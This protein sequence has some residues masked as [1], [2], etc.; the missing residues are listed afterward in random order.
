MSD[1][2]K[3]VECP[4]DAWQGLPVLMPAEVKADYL[5]TLV[6]AG[7]KHIDAVSFVSPKAVPQMADS[8]RVLEYLMAP[9]D[10]EIIAIAV[11]AKGAERAIR[12]GVVQTL[13]FPYSI[14]ATFLE[15]NQN[16]RPEE[17]IEALE[18]IGTLAF[19]G[20]LDVVA[21]LSM[22]FGNPYGDAWS[23]DE[24]VDACD[25]LIDSGVQRISL[26]DTVGLATPM[27]I[28]DTVA[29]VLAVHD[30]IEIGVHLHARPEDAAARIRAAYKAGCRRFD[31]AI[32]G[33]GG[34]PF[35]QDALVGNIPTETL[36]DVLGELGAEL[37]ELLPLD[38]LL[39]LNAEIAR[40]YGAARQ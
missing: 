26:A 24:V 34:C 13:G 33:L 39:H 35:A 28:A 8:E 11:N 20:G 9:E 12:T 10:V 6:E 38:G 31:A 15:R 17:A 3:I 32:G 18:E 36:L 25:L 14:S 21:Y 37:P 22:A 19:K 27:K 1:L 2:V 5:R 4:R 40:K 23:I 7:F 16:Q 30:E 29:D